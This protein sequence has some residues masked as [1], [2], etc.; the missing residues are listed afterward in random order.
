MLDAGG[1]SIPLYQQFSKCGPRTQLLL[2]SYYK[3]EEKNIVG[4]DL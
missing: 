3:S 1:S 2:S 4:N